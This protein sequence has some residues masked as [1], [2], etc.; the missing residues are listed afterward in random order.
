MRCY[1]VNYRQLHHW[2]RK[3]ILRLR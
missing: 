1:Y 2:P 3:C